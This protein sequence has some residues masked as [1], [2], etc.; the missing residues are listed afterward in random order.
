MAR[1][2]H[3]VSYSELALSNRIFYMQEKYAK[4]FCKTIASTCKTRKEFQ[5]KHPSAYRKALHEHWLDEF[6][7]PY[8]KQ[9]KWTYDEFVKVAKQCR[10]VSD[11]H[12][13]YPGAYRHAQ[14]CGWLD[15]YQ[16]PIPK[17]VCRRT[18]EEI[19]AVAKQY[20]SYSEFYQK[21]RN[22]YGLAH[23]RKLLPQFTWLI[24]KESANGVVYRDNVYVYEFK[25]YK[26]AYIGRTIDPI[27]RHNEHSLYEK[28]CVWKFAHTHNCS[29]P[30]PIYVYKNVNIKTGPRLEG[31]VMQQYRDN[32]WTLLNKAPAGSLGGMTEFSKSTCINIAK[33]YMYK[34][35]LFNERPEIYSALLRHKW[36]NQCTWLK[37]YK[38]KWDDITFDDFIKIAKKYRTRTDF[39]H[40][41]SA[42][43]NVANER[44]WIDKLYT[45]KIVPRPVVQ[46]TLDGQFIAEYSSVGE[47]ARATHC[48]TD[49]I[50]ACCKHR[51][52]YTHH[53]K[54]EYKAPLG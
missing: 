34:K 22:F 42:L 37:S 30:E 4:D 51:Q 5:L 50:I 47:A 33:R 17:R 46:Y 14:K 29:I 21:E 7:L 41:N 49:R 16:F 36:M 24:R 1:Y 27:R 32:G 39:S 23:R 15:T 31:E 52:R 10:S 48:D 26:V 2:S 25:H 45:R 44:G 40:K 35:D 6:G 13:N 9:I 43:Y 11:L 54:F 18:D 53:F 38:R 8:I 20:T 19:I 3:I 12:N 28:G